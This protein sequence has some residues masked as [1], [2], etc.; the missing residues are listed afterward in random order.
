MDYWSFEQL[1]I[2][3]GPYIPYEGAVLCLFYLLTCRKAAS[4]LVSGIVPSI[5]TGTK[6]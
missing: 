5:M 6:P 3:R 4:V 2:V 1:G